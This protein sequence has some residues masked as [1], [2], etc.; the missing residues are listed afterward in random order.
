VILIAGAYCQGWTDNAV[1][2][3]KQLGRGLVAEKEPS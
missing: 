3:F 2:A 1:A